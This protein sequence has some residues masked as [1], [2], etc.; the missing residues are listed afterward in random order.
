MSNNVTSR[1][2]ESCF[3][4]KCLTRAIAWVRGSGPRAD[5]RSAAPSCSHTFYFYLFFYFYLL[6]NFRLLFFVC[7]WSLYCAIGVVGVPFSTGRV[8]AHHK[9]S[10]HQSAE[11]DL[12]TI[13]LSVLTL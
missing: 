10:A 6:I 9:H 4:R 13:L 3:W 8:L 11:Y 12:S 2:Q 1:A 7:L 5:G